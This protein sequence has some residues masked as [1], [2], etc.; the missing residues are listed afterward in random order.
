MADLNV[1]IKVSATDD[2]EDGLAAAKESLRTFMDA[3]TQAGDEFVDQAGAMSKEAIV[4]GESCSIAEHKIKENAQAVREAS[5]DYKL[6]NIEQMQYNQILRMTGSTCIQ[7][8]STLQGQHNL[9]KEAINNFVVSLDKATGGFSTYVGAGVQVLGMGIEMYAQISRV[10]IMWGTHAA[11]VAT[12]TT[13]QALNT[14]ETATAIPI[15]WSFNAALAANPAGAVAIAI[16]AMAAAIGIAYLAMQQ[17]DNQT[18]EAKKQYDGLIVTIDNLGVKLKNLYAGENDEVRS[19]MAQR[20][21]ANQ[22]V[23]TLGEKAA[24]AEKLGYADRQKN[25]E[26]QQLVAAKTVN[27]L[28]AMIEEARKKGPAMAELGATWAKE[29]SAVTKVVFKSMYD[30]AMGE[31]KGGIGGVIPEDSPVG[32]DL[33]KRSREFGEAVADA[34][35]QGLKDGF[36]SPENQA[37]IDEAIAKYHLPL[38]PTHSPPKVGPLHDIDTWGKGTIRAYSEGMMSGFEELERSLS[39]ELGSS[40]VPLL[41]APGKGSSVVSSSEVRS[42]TNVTNNFNISGVDEESLARN[43]LRKIRGALG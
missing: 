16:G 12:A 9:V 23:I 19:L 31:G 32:R 24:A 7:W 5:R 26:D 25:Y 14:A 1:G 11:A 38:G 39:R 10:A 41:E 40:I 29:A 35:C 22:Q 6:M 20:E 43:I 18:A 42:T 33:K 37:I 2:T 17:M 15:Q 30:T 3:A 4:V 27:E 8:G 13:A 34:Y 21:T 36:Y 28:D